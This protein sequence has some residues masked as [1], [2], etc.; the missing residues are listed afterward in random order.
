MSERLPEVVR[1]HRK[2]GFGVP[3]AR[4]LRE[5]D[6]LRQLVSE[7]P[8]LSPIKDGPFDSSKLKNV[9]TQFLQG[10]RKHE[11]LVRQLTMIAIW[12]QSYFSKVNEKSLLRKQVTA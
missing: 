6:E 1:N 3:W 11:E 10:E 8:N 9:I 12:Y 2:W 4:Y 5:V 7:L